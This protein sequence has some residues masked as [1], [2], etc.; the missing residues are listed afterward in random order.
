MAEPA[1]VGPSVGGLLARR[2]AH[3]LGAHCLKS[4]DGDWTI[5]S[6]LYRF[7]LNVSAKQSRL[8]LATQARIDR[9]HRE[10]VSAAGWRSPRETCQGG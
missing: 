2:V 7:W 3:W 1:V 10:A 4:A 9:A 5:L 8:D 6:S